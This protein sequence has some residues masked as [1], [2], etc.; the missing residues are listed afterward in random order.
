M[1]KD[2]LQKLMD[3]ENQSADSFYKI[4]DTSYYDEEKWSQARKKNKRSK[5]RPAHK[6]WE[7]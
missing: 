4:D 7:D 6:K 2:K 1:K 3:V 5:P